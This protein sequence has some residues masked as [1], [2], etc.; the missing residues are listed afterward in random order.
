MEYFTALMGLWEELA[1]NKPSP[2]CSCGAIRECTCDF[3]VQ[4]H[5]EME[6]EKVYHLLAGLNPEFD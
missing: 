1:Y 6:E 2:T 5:K 4:L 3:L